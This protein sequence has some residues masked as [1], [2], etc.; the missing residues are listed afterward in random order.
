MSNWL[1][2]QLVK[3]APRLVGSITIQGLRFGAWRKVC[4]GVVAAGFGVA[5]F[6]ADGPV[7]IVG[8]AA[9]FTVVSGLLAVRDVQEFAAESRARYL[10]HDRG[11][12]MSRAG[13]TPRYQS[14]ERRSWQVT[15]HHEYVTDPDVNRELDGSTSPVSLLADPYRL[16]EQLLELKPY[17]LATRRRA[18]NVLFDGQKVRLNT[19]LDAALL[20]SGSAVTLQRTSYFDSVLTNELASVDI[21]RRASHGG[22]QTLIEGARACLTDHTGSGSALSD[23]AHS[24]ASNSIGISTLA[25]TSD[26]CLITTVQAAGSAQSPNLIAPSGSGSAD[27]DDVHA[28]DRLRDFIV[29]AM[30]REL[31]EET[32]LENEGIRVETALVGFARI[33]ERGGKP[34]FFGIS[35]L[36]AHSSQIKVAKKEMV[37]VGSAQSA[38][39]DPSRLRA[40]LQRLRERDQASFAEVTFVA[41]AL[42]EDALAAGHPG[43]AAVLGA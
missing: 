12:R 32:G 1:S 9:A 4:F 5:T 22:D 8:L 13:L 29:R 20:A 18:G 40:E 24:H 35:R 10:K 34:E 6:S 30:E 19:D 37:F 17:V 28:G 15:Q 2:T 23:L 25:I 39:I 16:P 27:W 11:Q 41:F 36:H 14:Y 43:A 7:W 42:A 31:L 38:P 21:Y 26:D 3:R 33:I